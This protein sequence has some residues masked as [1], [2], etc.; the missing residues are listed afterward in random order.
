[1]TLSVQPLPGFS[2]LRSAPRHFLRYFLVAAP[3]W[4]PANG[5]LDYEWILGVRAE[6]DD[7]A[8]VFS[9][10]V[11]HTAY[12][13]YEHFRAEN[14]F[15]KY[16]DSISGISARLRLDRQNYPVVKTILGGYRY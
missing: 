8:R 4:Q 15:S 14:R 13:C 3:T 9:A 12:V 11:Q 6:M 10:I 2:L 5:C 7:N 16:D 1:M